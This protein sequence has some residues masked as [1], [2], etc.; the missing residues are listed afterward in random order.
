MEM[1]QK[2]MHICLEDMM[3]LTELIILAIIAAIAGAIGQ[4][5]G[6]SW[7][8][9]FLTALVL[10][11]IGAFVG[12]WLARNLDLPLIL[13]VTIGGVRFPIIWAIIGSALFIGLLSL[14]GGAGG[15]WWGI[16]PPTRAVLGLSI[17]LALLAVLVST[18]TLSMNVSA[19]TL[20]AGA[21][22]ILL[23]GNLIKGL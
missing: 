6:G 17:L 20:M 4:S 10:G 9:G 15:R 12:T 1:A 19:F 7:R 22:V 5:L 2:S 3:T 18:G 11:F 21:Y 13:P 16:T 23:L 14:I 8:G